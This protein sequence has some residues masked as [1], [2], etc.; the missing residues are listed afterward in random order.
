MSCDGNCAINTEI[1]SAMVHSRTACSKLNTSKPRSPL[2][3]SRLS[4]ARLH[5]V[6][7]RNMYSEHGFDALMRPEAGHVCQSLIVVSNCK[8]GSA[9]AHAALPMRFHR[10]RA[11]TVLT[12]RPSVRAFK[13]QSP[14]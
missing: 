10:S 1:S 12:T 2:N 6:L 14:C 8:P 7:S 11:F 9:H 3:G 5:A 13:S 4:D